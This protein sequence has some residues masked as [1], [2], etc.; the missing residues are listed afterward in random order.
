MKFENSL[1]YAKKADRSDPLRAFRNRFIIPKAKGK[2]SIYFMGNSLGLQ[3]KTTKKWITEEL[4]DWAALGGEGT[5]TVAAR[6]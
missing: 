6:G 3:P 2:P 5:S 1:A 4:E